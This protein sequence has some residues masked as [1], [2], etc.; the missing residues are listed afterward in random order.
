[1]RQPLLSAC[2]LLASFALGVGTALQ[3]QKLGDLDVGDVPGMAALG[4]GEIILDADCQTL[5]VSV[6]REHKLWL[7]GLHVGGLDDL[8][9]LETHLRE[10]EDYRLRAGT[11]EQGMSRCRHLPADVTVER[12]VDV[13]APR[14]LP[15]G[16]LARLLGAVEASG[17][18]PVR[19]TLVEESVRF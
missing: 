19:L 13:K 14:T 12:G 9:P 11:Y 4:P 18:R 7:N 10:I 6:D 5:R 15:Y 8:E 1:M 16:D 17:L 3:V 2:A